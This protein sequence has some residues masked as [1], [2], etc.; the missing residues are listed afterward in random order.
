MVWR[1]VTDPGPLVGEFV[2]R[3]D[4]YRPHG[5]Y[6]SAWIEKRAGGHLF[7]INLSKGPGTTV[8]PIA[9]GSAGRNDWCVGFNLSRK[10]F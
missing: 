9:R 4:G 3:A 2:P 5:N 10:F 8:G 6:G 1:Q 7:Q